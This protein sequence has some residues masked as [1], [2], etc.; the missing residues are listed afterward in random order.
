MLDQRLISSTWAS[1][2]FLNP[3]TLILSPLLYLGIIAPPFCPTTAAPAL[4]HPFTT[5]HSSVANMYSRRSYQVIFDFDGTIT[6]K[7]TIEPLVQSALAFQHPSMSPAELSQT[8]LAEAWR[9]CKSQYLAEL[10]AHYEKENDKPSDDVPVRG[11]RALEREQ[12]SLDALWDVEMASVQRV[13]ESGIF[14]GIK[15]QSFREM[16]RA[17]ALAGRQ[18]ANDRAVVIREDFPEFL[19]WIRGTVRA[20]TGVVSVNWNKHWVQ[21][22]MD[23]V[24]GNLNDYAYG[25][26][27]ANAVDSR[28]GMIIGYPRNSVGYNLFE[29]RSILMVTSCLQYAISS[30]QRLTSSAPKRI[31]WSSVLTSAFHPRRLSQCI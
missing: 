23:V 11:P 2:H 19:G 1:R 12:R 9:N 29:R 3:Q 4:S 13:G 10:S 27:T 30:L 24:A 28:T 15:F 14:K 20:N 5:H 18:G 26:V 6:A 25:Y 22:V 17:A 31:C 21:G 8:P 7:D 16:G